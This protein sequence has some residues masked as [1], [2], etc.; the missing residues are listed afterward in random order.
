MAN[1]LEALRMEGDYK[2][3]ISKQIPNTV[4]KKL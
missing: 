2:F 4:V 3:N 1:L